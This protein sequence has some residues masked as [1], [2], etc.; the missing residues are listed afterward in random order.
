MLNRLSHPGAHDFDKYYQSIVTGV[1]R[2]YK[3]RSDVL[4]LFRNR[5]RNDYRVPVNQMKGLE[6]DQHIEK[7]CGK[8]T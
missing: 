4:R 2:V 6:E 1:I 7:P 5:L 8:V 3:K